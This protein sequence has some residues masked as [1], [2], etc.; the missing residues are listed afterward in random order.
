M[1]DLE[2]IKRIKEITITSLVR[3]E[4]FM[5]SL[6]LKGGNAIS[7]GY[8]LSERASY[9]LDFSLEDDFEKE[10]KEVETELKKLL[11]IGFKENGF[12][13]FEL[14]LN[15]KPKVMNDSLKDFWGGYYLE[16]K[17]IHQ[18]TWKK[19][20][21]DM[22]KIRI[23]AIALNPNNSTKFSID[24]SKNEYIGDHREL[25]DIDG[26]AYYV[27]APEL[28]IFEK[29]R[30]LAQKLPEYSKEV[31]GT[32]PYKEEERARPRDFYDINV[33]MESFPDID[34]SLPA[35]KELL[36]NVFDAKRVPYNFL[37]KI[38]EMESVHRAAYASVKDT[39]TSTEVDRGFDHYYN[40]FLTNFEHLLD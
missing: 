13:V 35:C 2:L 34:L 26:Y 17:L 27:Y 32:E 18:E 36:R 11:E 28:I 31:L 25:R 30:A 38:R 22:D 37:R 21:P 9:D 20:Y 29:V 12:V 5:E 8:G 39:L 15:A 4:G 16:F 23:S 19:L 10:I 6:V 7:M 24:I 40:F 3:D 33:L 14:K 1:I